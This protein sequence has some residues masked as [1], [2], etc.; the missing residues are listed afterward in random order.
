MPYHSL[1][2]SRISTQHIRKQPEL[3]HIRAVDVPFQPLNFGFGHFRLCMLFFL[4]LH[5]IANVQTNYIKICGSNSIIPVIL[6]C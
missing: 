4:F 5:V 1:F 2:Q 3:F 6:S